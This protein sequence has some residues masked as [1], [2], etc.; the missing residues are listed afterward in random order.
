M[1]PTE[2]TNQFSAM[3]ELLHAITLLVGLFGFAGLGFYLSCKKSWEF[4]FWTFAVIWFVVRPLDGPVAEILDYG[5]K[6]MPLG[7]VVVMPFQ[8]LWDRR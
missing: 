1:S 3:L 6:G 4:A 8:L 2:I 7:I 5:I